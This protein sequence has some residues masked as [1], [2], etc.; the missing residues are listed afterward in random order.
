M[1]CVV[2]FQQDSYNAVHRCLLLAFYCYLITSAAVLY[3]FIHEVTVCL[4]SQGRRTLHSQIAYLLFPRYKKNRKERKKSGMGGRAFSYQAPLL[5]NQLPVWVQLT[6][7]LLLRLALKPYFW[8]KLIGLAHVN[9]KPPYAKLL[10]ALVEG[11]FLRCPSSFLHSP[12]AAP[13]WGLFLL[14]GSFSLPQ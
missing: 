4:T 10:R 8:I 3:L 7:S 11:R 13:P 5:W 6:V 14:K 9:L 12:L 2:G 1:F